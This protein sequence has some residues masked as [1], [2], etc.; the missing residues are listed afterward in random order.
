M[1][2]TNSNDK[3]RYA[4]VPTSDACSNAINKKECPAKETLCISIEPPSTLSN[5]KILELKQSVVAR[6]RRNTT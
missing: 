6:D 2:D 5:K 4:H 1:L 3:L